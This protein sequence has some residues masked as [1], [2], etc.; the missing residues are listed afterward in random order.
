MSAPDP[1][2]EI[3]SKLGASVL[4]RLVRGVVRDLQAMKDGLQSGDDSGL[5][6]I[7]DEVCVQVQY[8]E[9]V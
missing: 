8:Q 7:W 2:S 5:A 1:A 9:S 4:D 3:V 6:N